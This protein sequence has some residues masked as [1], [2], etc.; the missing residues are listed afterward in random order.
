MKL[1]SV[2]S[3]L[4]ICLMLLGL[5]PLQGC[6]PSRKGFTIT[7]AHLNDTHSH[8][9]AA[10]A[11]MVINGHKATVEMGGMARVKRA[12]DELRKDSPNMMLLHAG[13][14]V[15]GTLYFNL[16]NGKPDFEIL[17]MLG[18]DAMTFGNHEFD[19]GPVAIPNYLITARFPVLSANI[20]FT[21]EPAISLLVHPYVI[22][23]V[24]GEKMGIVGL[25]TETT[26]ISTMS[27]GKARFNN[28]RESLRRTIRVLNSKGVDK[29][30]V[31][32]HLGYDEDK[33]LAMEVDGVDIIVGGHSHSL[34]GNAATLQPL[35]LKPE[36]AYPTVVQ[37]AQGKKV[38]VL[39][40]WQ[41]G[42]ILGGLEVSFDKAGEITG[43][44]DRSRWMVSDRYS[45]DGKP[46]QKGSDA[47]KE[48]SQALKKAVNA[49]PVA[50]DPAM[51][52]FIAPYTAKLA[53]YRNNVLAKADNDITPSLNGGPGPL[54][55]DSMKAS[56]PTAKLAL[57]NYGGIRKGL[58]SGNISVG[59]VMEVLPFG[60]TLNIIDLSGEELKQSLEEG[61]DFL[62]KKFAGVTPPPLPYVSGA[63]YTVNVKAAYGNR[64]VMLELKDEKGVY[65]PCL[66]TEIYRI[67]V[68][69]FIAG[70]GD[71]FATIKSAKRFRADSGTIDAD[72]F[73]AFLKAKGNVANPVEVRIAVVPANGVA[74]PA[75]IAAHNAAKPRAA[76]K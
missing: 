58:T 10:P 40:A 43:F 47:Y 50:E 21:E 24:D 22:R 33:Q 49:E 8:I 63:R 45:R 27:V 66:P 41:W 72:A 39:Q 37:T 25:T 32:S 17:N 36:G 70:G 26:P 56:V 23:H 11:A 46:V 73:G 68:N 15:Q 18:V 64:V 54:V 48:I 4:I 31:L 2:F 53:T 1:K 55:A 71:G 52:A 3:C 28:S 75:G 16:F 7:V 5:L 19:R 65:R 62:L 59:D 69:N 74:L 13:D 42:F 44:Q 14:A 20:D 51:A 34:L 30:I 60:N 12:V 6:G 29:I 61:I 38:L 76:T 57:L 9:E 35:G 67:V